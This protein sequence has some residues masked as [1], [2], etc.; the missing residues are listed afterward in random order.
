MEL[1]D[2]LTLE[3]GKDYVIC[4]MLSYEGKEYLFLMEVDKDENVL[5]NQMIVYKNGD[6]LDE[7][8]DKD[9]YKVISE[10]FALMFA[11]DIEKESF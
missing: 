6:Y 5:D 2:I 4:K 1:Y 3:D 8:K 7:I 9:L 11:D 10:K